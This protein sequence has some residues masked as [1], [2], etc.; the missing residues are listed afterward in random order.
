MK[1][2]NADMLADDPAVERLVALGRRRGYV[3]FDDLRQ[4]LPIATMSEAAIAQAVSRLE[5]AGIIIEV[6]EELVEPAHHDGGEPASGRP[7]HSGG[8]PEHDVRLLPMRRLPVVRQSDGGRGSPAGNSRA[9]RVAVVLAVA[10]LAA[11]LAAGLFL[12]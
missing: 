2:S 8:A 5:Q 12:A 11:L 7:A 3:T 1:A 9:A 4:A 6:D 10:T